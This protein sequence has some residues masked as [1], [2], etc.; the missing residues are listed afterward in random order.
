MRGLAGVRF[1]HGVSDIFARGEV[2]TE[3]GWKIATDIRCPD[4]AFESSK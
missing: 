4:L 3:N 2:R 1:V